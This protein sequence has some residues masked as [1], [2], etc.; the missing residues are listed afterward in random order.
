MTYQI[1]SNFEENFKILTD[2]NITIQT[3]ETSYAFA[4]AS[5]I[6]YKP[7]VNASF[8]IYQYTVHMFKGT[9]TYD[10]LNATYKLQYSDD[11]GENWSDWGDNTE[12]FVH[13]SGTVLDIRSVVDVKFAISASGWNDVKNLR[14]VAKEDSGANTSLHV[15]GTSSDEFYNENSDGIDFQ[16]YFPSVSCY[17]V[18]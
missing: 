4:T 3:L 2:R 9:I 15:T 12:V 17:S 7:S 6:S 14:L 18:N 11:S 13:S 8:V 16:R 1:Q 5:E 10:E